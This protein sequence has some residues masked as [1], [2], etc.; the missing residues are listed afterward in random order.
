MCN[1]VQDKRDC[2]GKPNACIFWCFSPHFISIIYCLLSGEF[3]KIVHISV[4]RN[5]VNIME[6]CHK[7]TIRNK[8]RFLIF[9][10]LGSLRITTNDNDWLSIKRIVSMFLLSIAVSGKLF[11][12]MFRSIVSI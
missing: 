6:F 2:R 12:P 8:T 4:V 1:R 9:C 7:K 3:L 10:R 5:Y 11:I